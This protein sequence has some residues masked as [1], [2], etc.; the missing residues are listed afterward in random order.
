MSTTSPTNQAP[1][2]RCTKCGDEGGPFDATTGR[3]E[4]C[5]EAAA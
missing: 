4:D 2:L 3:C 1:P 5:T